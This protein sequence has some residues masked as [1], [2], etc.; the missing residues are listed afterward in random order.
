MEP[1]VKANALE[2]YV[3][4]TN[5]K[6]DE[7]NVAILV[8]EEKQEETGDDEKGKVDV[9]EETDRSANTT[10]RDLSPE[11]V[12]QRWIVCAIASFVML[13]VGLILLSKSLKKVKE[14]EVGL[15]Y[16][17]YR[18]QLDDAA[19]SGGLFVGPPGFKFVKFP[20]TFINEDL[21]SE[22]VSRDGLRVYYECS[23]QY[24]MTE[25]NLYRAALKYRDFNKWA[26]KFPRMLCQVTRKGF[27]YFQNLI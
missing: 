9:I 19:K 18:K 4:D 1:Y 27:F 8:E 16:L 6:K 20:S 23:F 26:G 5:D 3:K 7:E 25:E 2:P 21:A 17:K 11:E 10:R 13:I 22:C 24:Q 12:Q 15:K 14:T